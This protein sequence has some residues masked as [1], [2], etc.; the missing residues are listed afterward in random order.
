MERIRK[1]EAEAEAERLAW[2]ADSRELSREDREALKAQVAA[3]KA[4]SRAAAQ[5]AKASSPEAQARQEKQKVTTLKTL[6]RDAANGDEGAVIRGL[7]KLGVDP[8]TVDIPALVDE[9]TSIGV[10]GRDASYSQ[11]LQARQDKAN[12][13]NRS[14][15]GVDGEPIQIVPR[16]SQQYLDAPMRGTSPG[17]VNTNTEVSEA[18]HKAFIRWQTEV[19]EINARNER[20]A[21]P[22]WLA[23]QEKDR[24]WQR[25]QQRIAGE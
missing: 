14:I 17:P 23:K 2:N 7:Q 24:A 1:Q 8:S 21:M 25:Y 9:A 13:Y 11:R 16:S 3:D 6:W 15:P 19:D 20:G 12:A 5:A 10:V 18:D 4:E 22:D